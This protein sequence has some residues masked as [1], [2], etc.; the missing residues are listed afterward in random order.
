MIRR[1]IERNPG[2]IPVALHAL[3]ADHLRRGEL[4]EAYDV[5]LR[6]SDS[7]FFWRALMRAAS[8]GLLGRKAEAKREA[9]ELLRQKPDF[10]KRGRTLIG[11][12]IKFPELHAR[13][14]ERPRQGRARARLIRASIGSSMSAGRSHRWSIVVALT[15]FWADD[16]GLSG[17][18][19]PAPDRRS[20][21]SRRSCRRAAGAAWPATSPTPCC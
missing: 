14:V 17:L 20:S 21:S 4:E 5:A 6:F 12:Y 13:I 7:T 18:L 9:A 8:L 2:H 15:R 11:R 10:A 19:G 1:S 16:K 3:W